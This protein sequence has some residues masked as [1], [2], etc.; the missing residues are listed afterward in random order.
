MNQWIKKIQENS[1]LRWIAFFVL[2]IFP[3]MGN[4]INYGWFDIRRPIQFTLLLGASAILFS[5]FK[6]SD[7]KRILPFV[8]G[9]LITTALLFVASVALIFVT[10]YEKQGFT[11]VSFQKAFFNYGFLF[12]FLVV[13]RFLLKKKE[14]VREYFIAQESEPVSN[15]V[16]L[17]VFLMGLLIVFKAWWI[18]PLELQAHVD[19]GGSTTIVGLCSTTAFFAVIFALPASLWVRYVVSLPYI[20]LLFFS[21]SR[22]AYVVF[23]SLWFLFIIRSVLGPFTFRQKHAFVKGSLMALVPLVALVTILGPISL[24]SRLYPY[25]VSEN[26]QENI[27]TYEGRSAQ[28]KKAGSAELIVYRQEELWNRLSRLVRAFYNFYQSPI[29]SDFRK[30]VNETLNMELMPDFKLNTENYVIRGGHDPKDR[31]QRLAAHSSQGESR[32][33]IIRNTL[34]LIYMRPQGWW[35]YSYAQLIPL[36]CNRDMKC[37]Y[38]HN[39]VLEAIFYF[40]L[41]TGLAYI[42]VLG[43]LSLTF[44]RFAIKGNGFFLI[45]LSVSILI[46]FF[47]AQFTGTYYDLIVT[48]LLIA[49]FLSFLGREIEELEGIS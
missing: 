48:G 24:S 41:L 10:N 6:L 25:Y 32:V 19:F 11:L 4:A 30:M 38:P 46:H 47:G 31:W 5:N 7:L 34:E 21:T 45:G 23:F 29:I 16:A 37:T 40:G 35:P 14:M 44:M 26:V 12:L 36:Y 1:D 2:L 20:Y 17:A 49:L 18:G 8:K 42:F 28:M 39:I 13:A 9:P 3:M 15:L 33:E 27:W 22:T 43:F